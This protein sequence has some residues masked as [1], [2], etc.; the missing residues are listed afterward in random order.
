MPTLREL[1]A[2]EV[3]VLAGVIAKARPYGAPRWQAAGI[4]ATFAK[5]AHLDAT[6]V[7]MAAL[8][9][10]QDRTANTPAQI[11]IP[12]SEC[13]REKLADPVEVH[14]PYVRGHT[15]GVC[16]YPEA[17]CRMRWEGDHEFEQMGSVPKASKDEAH[18][19]VVELKN[20]LKP[21]NE[22]ETA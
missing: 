8:R 2:E 9:L 1:T 13:W 11:A 19:V 17:D 20:H 5:V 22:G 21:M 18:E 16:G 4:R 15:C 14:K 7:L 12:S 10:S 3:S 6:D